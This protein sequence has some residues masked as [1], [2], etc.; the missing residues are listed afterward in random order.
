MAALRSSYR[1]WLNR[2]S[3]IVVHRPI[4][5]G[6]IRLTA[7]SWDNKIFKTWRYIKAF[8]DLVEEIGKGHKYSEPSRTEVN[9]L[10]NAWMRCW[11]VALMVLTRCWIPSTWMADIED[12]DVGDKK[13][14]NWTH[15]INIGTQYCSKIEANPLWCQWATQTENALKKMQEKVLGVDLAQSCWYTTKPIS[16]GVLWR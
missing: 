7:M 5:S 9:L 15:N 1:R 11:E 8:G 4:P 14:R 10:R 3:V 12:W 13:I 16:Y 6:P 2:Y